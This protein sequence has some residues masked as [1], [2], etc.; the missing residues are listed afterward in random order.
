MYLLV[1]LCL[2]LLCVLIGA[3]VEGLS[4]LLLLSLARSGIAVPLWAVYAFVFGPLV[5]CSFAAVLIPW[6]FA[7]KQLYQYSVKK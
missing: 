6:Q 7:F 5:M 2:V 1:L 3:G 4:I